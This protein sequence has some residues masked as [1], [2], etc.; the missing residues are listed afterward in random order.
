MELFS[1]NK[2]YNKPLIRQILDL[3]PRY[4]FSSCTS[5]YKTD[6]GCSKYKTYDQFVTMSFG[7][8]NKCL[9]LSDISASIGV[10]KIFIKDLGL[11]QSPARSTMSD[12]NKKR[13]WEVYESL[14]YKLLAYY[15]N[16][17]V[18]QNKREVIEEIKDTRIKLIDSTTI[19]LCLSMFDWAK[20]RSG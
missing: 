15:E 13:K 12:G 18:A 6:K 14:Y 5:E 10:S 4:I 2:N 19:S 9:T 17:L 3:V 11:R 8:L 20:Y 16:I 7:Q 1:R